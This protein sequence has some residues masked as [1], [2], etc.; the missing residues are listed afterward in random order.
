MSAVLNLKVTPD[1]LQQKAREVSESVSKMKNDFDK[2]N[3]A[4][5]STHSYW[6]GMAGDQHRKLYQ[7][8]MEEINVI[9]KSLS[10]YPTDL[11][12]MAGIYKKSENTN[13]A[14]AAS[15]NSNTIH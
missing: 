14:V 2:L 3:S 4:L 6:K 12:Q 15:L 9:L 13:K 11:L 7:E 5:Q 1:Q 10:E 8:R